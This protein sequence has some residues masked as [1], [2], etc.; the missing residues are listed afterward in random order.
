MLITNVIDSNRDRTWARTCAR[1][2]ARTIPTAVMAL[3]AGAALAIVGVGCGGSN[4]GPATQTT[5]P[6][7]DATQG[8]AKQPE[9]EISRDART[10]YEGALAYFKEQESAGWTQNSCDDA[11]DKFNDV[12]GAHDSLMEARYMAALSYHRCNM[13]EKAEKAYQRVLDKNRE[14]ALSMSNLGEIYFR[15]GQVDKARNQW[16]GAVKADS[17]IVAAHNNLA[18]L[19][20]LEM[21]R[22]G[23]RK[24]WNEIEAKARLH[25]SSS[26]AVDSEQ[27]KTYVLYGLLYLEGYRRNPNRLDL[28]KLLL[29]EGAKRDKNYA[30]LYNARGLL[31]MA[32]NNQGEALANF[33]RAVELDGSFVEARL[34]VGNITLGFRKYDEAEQQ[35]QNA[36]QLDPASYDAHLGY[37]IAKRGMGDFDA[38]ESSYQK[39]IDLDSSR[40]EAYFNLGVLYKDFRANRVT[41]LSES[42]QAYQT[43][44]EYFQK[45]VSNPNASESGKREA[46]DNMADCN[47]IIKQLEEII[48]ASAAS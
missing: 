41:E 2:R 33:L 45:Y 18:W 22:T 16:E 46:Q 43:A 20:I 5:T 15:K 30:P 12:A 13:D 28:A 34:N 35:F 47:K 7:A 3:V 8:E 40:P 26:L 19:H 4:K 27:V 1:I 21:R 9:R 6:S 11:A 36:I 32:R 31:Q 25:L 14:H 38:A 23:K 29:D 48:A 17:K 42:K 37:G 10:D 44:R 24:A 39:A